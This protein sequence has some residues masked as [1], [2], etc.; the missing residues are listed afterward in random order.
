MVKVPPS[1][2]S[3]QP[4]RQATTPTAVTVVTPPVTTLPGQG[5]EAGTGNAADT[6]SGFSI[7]NQTG[8]YATYSENGNVQFKNTT[9]TSS[10][11]QTPI[12]N[13][14]NQ[15]TP[16]AAKSMLSRMLA[17]NQDQANPGMVALLMARSKGYTIENMN[18]DPKA[19]LVTFST[20]E[21]P[22]VDFNIALGPPPV[23]FGS[24]EGEDGKRV[25]SED[26]EVGNIRDVFAGGSEGEGALGAVMDEMWAARDA[27]PATP[28]T[29]PAEPVDGS[30]KTEAP[31]DD[32]A[33]ADST[34]PADPADS[35]EGPVEDSPSDSGQDEVK[36]DD[37]TTEPEHGQSDAP[38]V[39][40]EPVANDNPNSGEPS[41]APANPPASPPANPVII[42][43]QPRP[44]VQDLDKVLA[45]FKRLTP[46]SSPQERM[47][48][49]NDLRKILKKF[50]TPEDKVNEILLKF[51]IKPKTVGPNP[52]V[53]TS[54]PEVK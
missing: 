13:G 3:I 47:L 2:P 19:K 43:E 29:A 23:V 25:R 9:G 46:K 18:F 53:V 15:L 12:T 16:S 39:D 27:E 26:R 45:K 20:K 30:D 33:P 50:S 48:L 42:Q 36:G 52:T 4:T 22:A 31:S 40:H 51:G 24:K 1:S 21:N 32:P 7:D 5:T 54:P 11:V 49:E 44:N 35:A 6:G 8:A 37:G 28:D 14:I 34:D 41:P 38:H 17:N 10:L